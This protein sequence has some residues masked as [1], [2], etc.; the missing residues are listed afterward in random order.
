[1]PNTTNTGQ[2]CHRKNCRI[3]DRINYSRSVKS[4]ATNHYIGTIKSDNANCESKNLVYLLNCHTCGMQYVGETKQSLRCRMNNHMYNINNKKYANYLYSHFNDN[5]HGHCMFTIDILDNVNCT[6]TIQ[7]LNIECFWIKM[8]LT[9]YPL[10]LND[11]IKNF[12][13]ISSNKQYNINKDKHYNAFKIV[14]LGIRK[15]KNRNKCG[16]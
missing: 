9:A 12:G 7:R 6:E 13:C 8:L 2:R 4:Y 3:C 11:H 10:G 16:V 1:L 14:H 15:H 5:S